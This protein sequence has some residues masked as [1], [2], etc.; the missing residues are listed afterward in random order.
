MG[1]M[2]SNFA[3]K[4]DQSIK[5]LGMTPT[6]FARKHNL[7]QG[8]ISLWLNGKR[9]PNHKT[10]IALSEVFKKEGMLLTAD[11]FTF[12]DELSMET[13]NSLNVLREISVLK[14]LYPAFTVCLITDASMEPKFSVNEHV[15][16]I[17]SNIERNGLYIIESLDGFRGPRYVEVFKTYYLLKALNHDFD[18]IKLPKEHLARSF[19]IF[20]HRLP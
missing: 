7:S 9:F 8:S 17:E 1:K 3:K 20:W 10:M 12:D 14:K 13:L 19:K 11:L 5:Q 18:D 15:G 6:A 2:Q 16:G 4:L